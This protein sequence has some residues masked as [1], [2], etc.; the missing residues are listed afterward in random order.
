ML[1]SYS[2]C[3]G[4]SR[5]I[6]ESILYKFAA[7]IYYPIVYITTLLSRMPYT[8]TDI[9]I[10][11]QLEPSARGVFLLPHVLANKLVLDC[12]GN[13]YAKVGVEVQ[14]L[15]EEVLGFGAELNLIG[16]LEL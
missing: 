13:A 10:S 5:G 2:I 16:E 11:K 15:C 9:K 4:L 7:D 8:P 6:V 12:V 3:S 14:H 1:L